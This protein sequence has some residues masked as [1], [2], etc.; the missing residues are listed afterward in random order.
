MDS[1]NERLQRLA[2]FCEASSRDEQSPTHKALLLRLAHLCM[3]AALL[4]T[5]G[6]SSSGR[7]CQVRNRPTPGRSFFSVF[8]PQLTAHSIQNSHHIHDSWALCLSRIG[9]NVV[10]HVQETLEQCKAIK[11]SDDAKEHVAVFACTQRALGLLSSKASL[12][13][14]VPNISPPLHACQV[15]IPCRFSVSAEICSQQ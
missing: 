14:A 7:S 8:R 10:M 13:T 2:D 5:D 9:C 1:L 11:R 3:S 6:A 15:H 4:P 12:P